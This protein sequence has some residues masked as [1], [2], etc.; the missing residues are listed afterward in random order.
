MCW[1]RGRC[2]W[3]VREKEETDFLEFGLGLR[4]CVSSCLWFIGRRRLRDFRMLVMGELVKM[5]KKK[6]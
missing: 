4:H 1:L 2:W 6:M 3:C 5:E